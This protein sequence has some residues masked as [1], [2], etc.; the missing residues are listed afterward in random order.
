MGNQPTA[1]SRCLGNKP[2]IALIAVSAQIEP[3]RKS[4]WMT[5]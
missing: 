5:I 4:N 1:V 3:A 2:Q